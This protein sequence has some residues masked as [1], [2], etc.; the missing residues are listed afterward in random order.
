MDLSKDSKTADSSQFLTEPLLAADVVSKLKLTAE[1]KTQVDK[2][3]REFAGK[4]KEI[5]D[6][7]KNTPAQA[8]PAPAKGKKGAKPA[9]ASNELLQE[10]IKLREEYEEK[11]ND[12][13]TDAQKTALEEIK[14]KKAEALLNGGGAKPNPAKK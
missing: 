10:A 2:L 4:L 13:L 14:A 11:V 7:L 6:K 3:Q 9:S 12:I 1:Q 5:A 8:A